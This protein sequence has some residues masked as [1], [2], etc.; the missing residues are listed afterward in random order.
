ML[1]LC[2]L[3]LGELALTDSPKARPLRVVDDRNVAI[4]APLNVCFYAGLQTNCLRRAPYSAPSPVENFD[5]LTVEGPEHG[6]VQL[7]RQSLTIEEGAYTVRV[8]RKARLLITGLPKSTLTLS[9]Y[10]W[11]DPTFRK[12][13][14]RID[15]VSPDSRIP[16]GEF[17]LSLADGHSAPNLHLL[18]ASSGSKY[19]LPYRRH[20]GWSLLIRCASRTE[21]K[22]VRA[23]AVETLTTAPAGSVRVLG[24]TLTNEHG[25][26]V[27]NGL[28]E[29][30]VSVAVTA[31]GY[32]QKVLRGVSA[33][34][35]S[36]AFRDA[37]LER[38]GSIS[39]TV[40]LDD[41]PA[42]GAQ[43]QVLEQRARDPGPDRIA[44]QLSD[45]TIGKDGQCRVN[46]MPE[47]SYLLRIRPLGSQDAADQPVVVADE[48]TT[49][50]EVALYRI[51][52]RGRV[53]RGARPEPQAIVQIRNV[54]DASRTPSGRNAP[55]LPME[56][57][58]NED[59]EYQG[60]LWT[61][62]QY[63]FVVR[64]AGRRTPA[65][66][67][68]V[69][70]DR[71]GT[72]V[73]F[74]L[75]PYD[76]A[77]RVVDDRGN[78]VLEASVH[79]TL[80][81]RDHR[82]AAT[83]PNGSFS[84]PIAGEGSVSLEAT[85]RGYRR[86]DNVS[87]SISSE[88]EPP[89]VL[90]TLAKLDSVQG[91]VLLATGMPATNVGVASYQTSAGQAPVLQASMLT[92]AQGEFDVPRAAG[93]STRLF[94]TGLG[95]PLMVVDLPNDG[96]EQVLPC[97]SAA[98]GLALTITDARGTALPNE[99][100]LFR[101]QGNVIPRDVL[102]THQRLLGLAAHT[103]GAGL[104][105]FVGLPPGEYDIFSGAG[106]SEATVAAGLPYGHLTS[107]RLELQQVIELEIQVQTPQ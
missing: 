42:T 79:L 25:L 45:S 71:D 44:V 40:T 15:A 20:A 68:L 87:L 65:T 35:G 66:T 94:V 80:N 64:A 22:P 60:L 93:P 49:N 77:G 43:C 97:A 5:S 76:I 31:S 3:A 61:T 104:L 52:V 30:Y 37:T 82:L 74:R 70:V 24:K 4:T 86:S 58:T 47:G 1:S 7:A 50:V 14:F 9:L 84:F 101:W 88:T 46:K 53:V 56:V 99:T 85:K 72:T 10:R 12:P 89:A 26:G 34:P 28:S 103:D 48:Q 98:A 95:C 105:T 8:P 27:R 11:D 92:T 59:G 91:R 83:D 18:R 19:T 81:E 2:L 63:F 36:F 57:T 16:A 75:N 100:V 21:K 78:P 29:P 6:P 73:D 41:R 51:P 62:G 69:E 38:G 23:A 17:V 67:R 55:D 107:T 90:L 13:T 39:A 106:A 96:P 33:T 102:Y 54:A 32:L